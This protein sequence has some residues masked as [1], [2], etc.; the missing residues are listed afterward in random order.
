MPL[1][2]TELLEGFQVQQRLVLDLGEPL[3]EVDERVLRPDDC[4]VL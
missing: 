3:N 2:D 1:G 4:P